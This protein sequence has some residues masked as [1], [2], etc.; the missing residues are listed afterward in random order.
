MLRRAAPPVVLL[1]AVAAGCLGFEYRSENWSV[2]YP[3]LIA[4]ALMLLI[5]GVVALGRANVV[6]ESLRSA[7]T[8][9]RYRPDRYG[10]LFPVLLV[11]V[12]FH[13]RW[14]VPR[15][16]ELPDAPVSGWSVWWS[17]SEN[18]LWLLLALAFFLVARRM[19]ELSRQ[20]Q[21]LVSEERAEASSQG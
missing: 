1:L 17:D 3:G 21:E 12:A 2:G 6:L 20:L 11:S 5:V 14:G 16:L 9:E 13:Y 15:L 8:S 4:T 18:N 10:W 7:R 19:L